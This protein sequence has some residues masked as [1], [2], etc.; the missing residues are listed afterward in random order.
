MKKEEFKIVIAESDGTIAID[1]KNT[2]QNDG[3]C[4]SGLL[5]SVQSTKYQSFFLGLAKM[6]N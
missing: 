2:I 5:R 6:R 4:V 1:L 3:Y